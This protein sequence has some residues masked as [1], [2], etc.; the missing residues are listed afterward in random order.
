MNC[1]TS[2][3]RGT[4]LACASAATTPANGPRQ[5]ASESTMHH[6]DNSY[7]IHGSHDSTRPDLHPGLVR[8]SRMFS[9]HSLPMVYAVETTYHRSHCRIALWH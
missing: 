1:T 4:H 5:S 8:R 2:Q 3:T 7:P 9:L 6:R